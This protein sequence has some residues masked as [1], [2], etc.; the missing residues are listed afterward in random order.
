M[1]WY[2]TV[3][4]TLTALAATF[5]QAPGLADLTVYDGPEATDA[6]PLATLTV[7]QGPEDDPTAVTGQAEREGLSARRSQET[8][9]VMC[10]LSV[11]DPA[12]SIPAARARVF[13]FYAEVGAVLAADPRLGGAVMQAQPGSFTYDQDLDDTGATAEISFGVDVVA[14]TRV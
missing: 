8:Y 11:C 10:L 14:F 1:G 12:S 13:D 9:T 6:A 7:G 3:P 5:R 2:S 4:T